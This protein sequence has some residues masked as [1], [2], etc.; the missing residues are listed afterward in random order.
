MLL[1]LHRFRDNFSIYA[2][3]SSRYFTVTAVTGDFEAKSVVMTN[4]LGKSIK[5][6]VLKSSNLLNDKEKCY[7]DNKNVKG[8][9]RPV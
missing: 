2:S 8:H 1:H 9:K 5:V 4:R 6:N 3:L 7:D